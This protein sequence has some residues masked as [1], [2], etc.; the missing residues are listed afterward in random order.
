MLDVW[1]KTNAISAKPLTTVTLSS[2]KLYITIPVSWSA[3]PTKPQ[4]RLIY[5]AFHLPTL[6]TCVMIAKWY[7]NVSRCHVY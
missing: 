3:A 6:N 7:E 2:L 4:G 1:Y 5:E